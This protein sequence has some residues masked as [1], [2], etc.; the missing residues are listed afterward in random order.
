MVWAVSFRAP[1]KVK[2]FLEDMILL[3]EDGY[4]RRNHRLISLMQL[5]PGDRRRATYSVLHGDTPFCPPASRDRR[6]PPC[7][8]FDGLPGDLQPAFQ[9][10][11]L[12]A[13]LVS[14][15]YITFDE[16]MSMFASRN[17][18]IVKVHTKCNCKS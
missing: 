15:S 3:G 7:N 2:L 18:H 8:H 12:H 11:P 5:P 16:A 6:L 17:K 13:L 4:A 1:A 10:A 9:Q 14:R